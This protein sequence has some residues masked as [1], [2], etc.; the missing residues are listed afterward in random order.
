V[1]V[2][3]GPDLPGLSLASHALPTPWVVP[4]HLP[5]EHRERLV[6]LLWRALEGFEPGLRLVQLQWGERRLLERRQLR[7]PRSALLWWR[8]ESTLP[9]EPLEVLR[10]SGRFGSGATTF[11][12]DQEVDIPAFG[13]LGELK[14]EVLRRLMDVLL[15]ERPVEAV[16]PITEVLGEAS[17]WFT[18]PVDLLDFGETLVEAT[19]QHLPLP[20]GRAEAC[21]R[22]VAERFDVRRPWG[23]AEPIVRALVS[24]S[25]GGEVPVEQR[26]VLKR[27]GLVEKD[28]TP[29]PMADLLRQPEVLRRTLLRIV[30]VHPLR[31]PLEEIVPAGLG[32]EEMGTR[33]RSEPHV[34]RLVPGSAEELGRTPM[35]EGADKLVAEARKLLAQGNVDVFVHRM[36]KEQPH[37]T[38]TREPEEAGLRADVLM[39]VADEMAASARQDATGATALRVAAIQTAAADIYEQLGARTKAGKALVKVGVELLTCYRVSEALASLKRAR[40]LLEQ[41]GEKSALAFC[42]LSIGNALLWTG[43]FD[44]AEEAYARALGLYTQVESRLGEANTLRA[45]GN[46]H[47]RM[48]RLGQAEEAYARALGLYTQ[49][50]DRLG[51]AYTLLA[52]GDLHQRMSRL[53]QAE[54]AYA[55]ALGP[56]SQV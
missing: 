3:P 8:I 45:L 13:W 32:R 22:V 28:G 5:R 35:P 37:A 27:A 31:V 47:Q 23:G 16:E 33:E 38:R 17:G 49:V 7:L 43:P 56:F 10:E 44:E 19:A 54:E 11:D 15:D 41:E 6:L 53:G 14:M 42:L 51:E 26:E 2:F 40:T 39:A 24:I 34:P 55:R 52:L 25:S 18:S 12:F 50:E 46:L 20:D 21:A 4:S 1:R 48:S 29:V 9:V 30:S 36:L